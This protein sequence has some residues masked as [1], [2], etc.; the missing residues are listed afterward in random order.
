MPRSSRNNRGS[1][2]N[3]P[4][5]NIES[6]N[7]ETN[8]ELRLIQRLDAVDTNT[9]NILSEVSEIKKSINFITEETK[10]AKQEAKKAHDRINI[11]DD[12]LA[13][14]MRAN[15]TMVTENKQLKEKVTQMEAYS[16][17]ENLVFYGVPET[18]SPQR[19]ED[20][21]E[22]VRG[23]VSTKLGLGSLARDMRLVRCHRQGELRRPPPNASPSSAPRSAP[24]PRSIVCRFHW[25]GDRQ[26][27]WAERH[28]L[29]DANG[30][31][32][33]MAEDYPDSYQRDRLVLKQVLRVARERDETAHLYV[34]KL[35]YKS[36]LYGVNDLHKLPPEVNPESSCTADDPNTLVFFGRHSYLS[37]FHPTKIELENTQY[38]CV[39]QF[40]QSQKAELMGDDATAARIRA[41]ED[42]A[43]QKALGRRVS[44]Y[45]HQAWKDAAP[46]ILLK[47]LRAKFK[48][49]ALGERLRETGVKSIAEASIDRF[50]G[51]GIALSDPDVTNP[52]KWTG[53][54]LLG[55]SLEIVRTELLT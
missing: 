42:P 46:D 47:A 38:N 45:V 28:R 34:N 35:R 33:S 2:S 6:Q 13:S 11:I 9:Q 21:A 22:I 25:A 24:R 10:E 5:Q 15:A 20:C 1:V 17:R 23:T 43:K 3:D 18:S 19:R 52:S 32:I 53:G 27:I 50:W 29:R 48:N 30:G 37:N 31:G 4:S 55:K 49:V 44:N 14:L 8:M 26:L 16:R 41:E 7:I 36:R 40:L 54:N 39:E 12:K 51:C